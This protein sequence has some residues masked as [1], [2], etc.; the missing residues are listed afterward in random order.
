MRVECKKCHYVT[1][2][3]DIPKRCPYCGEAKTMIKASTAQDILD[4][5]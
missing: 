3:E 1:D 2:K 5:I 4:D